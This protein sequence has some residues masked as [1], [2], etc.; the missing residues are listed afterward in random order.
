MSKVKQHSTHFLYVMENFITIVCIY[1]SLVNLHLTPSGLPSL[2][3]I[4]LVGTI[5]K[6]WLAVPHFCEV[7]GEW[8]STV[9]SIAANVSAAKPTQINVSCYISKWLWKP[10]S[11]REHLEDDEFHHWTP[12]VDIPIFIPL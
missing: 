11:F 9:F 7:K 6:K 8:D 3:K 4:D 1:T 10:N 5:W 12:I 2:S